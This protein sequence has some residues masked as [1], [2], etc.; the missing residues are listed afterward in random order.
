MNGVLDAIPPEDRAVII[1]ELTHLNPAMLA[2]LRATQEPSSEQT[3]AAAGG[4][5]V[6]RLTPYGDAPSVVPDDFWA[7]DSRLNCS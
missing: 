5:R 7:D 4:Y 2:D 1:D 6:I 3:R